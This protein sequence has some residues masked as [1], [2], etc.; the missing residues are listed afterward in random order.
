MDRRQSRRDARL[1]EGQWLQTR[2]NFGLQLLHDRHRSPGPHGDRVHAE[3]KGLHRPVWP[4]WLNAVR[5]SVGSP[6]DMAKF[7]TAF[8][9]V[10]DAPVATAAEPRARLTQPRGRQPR[11]VLVPTDRATL[12]SLGK[13]PGSCRAFCCVGSLAVVADAMMMVHRA[14]LVTM[15][16]RVGLRNT[17]A[18]QDDD[19]GQ[20]GDSSSHDFL[21]D[22][23]SS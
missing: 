17:P 7:R 16:V 1:A 3:G 13:A 8:K 23:A 9:K 10:M 18:L 2:G 14:N 11:E 20:G 6:E 5:I 22:D 4:V 19:Q 15:M 12:I 21:H